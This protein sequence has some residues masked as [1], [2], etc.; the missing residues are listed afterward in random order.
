MDDYPWL[1]ELDLHPLQDLNMTTE[2]ERDLKKLLKLW[3]R[4]LKY[5]NGFS[6]SEKCRLAECYRTVNYTLLRH[7]K[8]KTKKGGAK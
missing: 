7:S 8:A 2:L 3:K 1:T 5:G 6:L 4:D